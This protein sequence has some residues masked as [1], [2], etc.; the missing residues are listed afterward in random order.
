MHDKSLEVLSGSV[1]MTL[2]WPE[3]RAAN[4][5]SDLG[6]LNLGEIA[7]EKAAFYEERLKRNLRADDDTTS[8]LSCEY[9][10]LRIVLVSQ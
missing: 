3:G 5:V 4:A 9:Y 6:Y 2:L 8:A 7:V 10:V 1:A